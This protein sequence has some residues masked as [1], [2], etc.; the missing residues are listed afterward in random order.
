MTDKHCEKCGYTKEDALL[1]AD[2]HRCE[3]KNPPWKDD[4]D[5]K[6][7]LGFDAETNGIPIWKEPSDSE[8]Q[9]HIVQ[10]AA[11]LV[12]EDTREEVDSM[13]VIVKPD[14]WEISQEM[15]DIHGISMEQAMDVG[16]PEPE[17]LQMYLEFDPYSSE[18][19]HA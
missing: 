7:I 18:A 13:D 6:L 9:P 2:H 1:N 5:R 3:N 12:D 17:A 15:T 4:G 14:G 8:N 10:L 11:I 16:I 19:L